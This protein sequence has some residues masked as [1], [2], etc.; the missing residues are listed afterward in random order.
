MVS[1]RFLKVLSTVVYSVIITTVSGVY[2]TRSE[3]KARGQEHTKS[4]KEELGF[5]RK[6][7]I[8]CRQVCSRGLVRRIWQPQFQS[9]HTFTK[10]VHVYYLQCVQSTGQGASTESIEPVKNTT[11]ALDVPV[12]YTTSQFS[13]QRFERLSTIVYLFLL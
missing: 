2:C 11:S 4:G 8:Y 7:Q 5:N 10:F 13:I 6:F 12:D 3:R 9:L 1:P